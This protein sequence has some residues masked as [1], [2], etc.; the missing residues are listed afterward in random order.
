MV[1]FNLPDSADDAVSN[2][3]LAPSASAGG[4]GAGV[5]AVS[6]RERRIQAAMVAAR[7]AAEMV[8]AHFPAPISLEFEKVCSWIRCECAALSFICNCIYQYVSGLLPLS[9]AI[10]EA[11][12]WAAALVQ[13]EGGAA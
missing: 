4:A 13:L 10:Q 7:Q 1:L 8:N 5:A 9:A 2:H 11:L 3:A 6:V 12:R